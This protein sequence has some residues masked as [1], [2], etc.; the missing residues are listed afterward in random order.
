MTENVSAPPR[1][2]IGV[3][4]E[5]HFDPTEYKLFN[6]MFPARGYQVDYISHLWGNVDSEYSSNPER[7]PA[8]N[9]DRI[10]LYVIV[11]T[12][13]NDVVLSDYKGFILIGAYAMDRL[14][15]EAKPIKGQPNQ[16]P[17]VKFLRKAMQTPG[18]K[19]GTICHSLWLLCADPQLLKGRKVTCANN[20]IYDVQNAGG[21]VQFDGDNGPRRLVVDQDL[22][23][24][25]HP[26]DGITEEFIECFIREIERG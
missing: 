4:I 8:T 24:A 13:I 5:N 6:K 12:E 14:R 21:D 22:I 19:I 26:A 10:E 7:D 1:S 9:K 3:L 25:K 20:L 11:K 16:S 2:K 18:L 17:A 23:T 15:Y